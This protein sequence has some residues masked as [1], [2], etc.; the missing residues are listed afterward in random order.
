[1]AVKSRYRVQF[2]Y[3]VAHGIGSVVRGAGSAVNIMPSSRRLLGRFN[4]GARNWSTAVKT[5][6]NSLTGDWRNVGRYVED[7]A[8]QFEPTD[9]D[10]TTTQSDD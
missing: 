6:T 2:H 9:P 5:D 10:S 7:S 8:Q 3:R 4:K 1:M